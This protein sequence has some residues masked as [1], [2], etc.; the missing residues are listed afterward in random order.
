MKREM[1]AGLIIKDKRLLLVHNIKHGL[2]I[3]PPGGKKES[4][5][6]WDE[7]VKR[8]VREELGIEVRPIRLFGVY[9]THS[10]EGEFSV[11]LYLCVIT[12]GEPQVRE[13]DKIPGFG[14]YSLDEIQELR[15]EGHLVPNMVEALADL[16]EYLRSESSL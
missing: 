9:D 2:R 12:S 7:S 15:E 11:H 16:K 8:E 4:G 5:E 1:S 14:W 13:P 3:E 10:P 6:S